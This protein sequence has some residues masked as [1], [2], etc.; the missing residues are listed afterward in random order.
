VNPPADCYPDC[1]F[2]DLHLSPCIACERQAAI[3]A[4]LRA[5]AGTRTAFYLRIADELDRG[6]WKDPP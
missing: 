5:W 2:V 6:A 1:P 3:V 4:W